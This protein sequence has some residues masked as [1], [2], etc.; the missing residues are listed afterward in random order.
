[1]SATIIQGDC[2][3]VLRGMDAGS[4]DAIV[5]DPPYEIGGQVAR[6][7]GAARVSLPSWD[8]ADHSWLE[9]GSRAVVSGGS[10]VAFCDTKRVTD[11]WRAMEGAGL[12]PRQ[13]VAWVKHAVP[14]NPRRGFQSALELAV[15]AINGRP[16][17]DWNG[18]ALTPNVWFG[19]IVTTDRL[20]ET[21]KP[22]DLM[23]W[24]VRL[25]TPPGGLVLD[26]FAGSGTTGIAC[27]LEGRRFIG[28]EREA[29][30]AETARSRIN[31]A[32]RQGMLSLEVRP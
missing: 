20:H 25:V 32:T 24:L 17:K 28:I 1:M 2:L 7:G 9:H 21:Q 5:T 8:V 16:A 29:K 4:V 12:S 27:H 14:P 3:E 10:V 15:W 6:G 23:R 26:P 31:D 18:G 19:N 13:V 30:H 22:V 11:L